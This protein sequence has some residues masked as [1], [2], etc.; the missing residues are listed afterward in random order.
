MLGNYLIELQLNLPTIVWLISEDS[1]LGPPISR[2]EL[3]PIDGEVL[4][5]LGWK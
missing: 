4:P 5:C 1:N 2:A 3:W